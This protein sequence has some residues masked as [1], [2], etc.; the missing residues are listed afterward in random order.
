LLSTGQEYV[1]GENRTGYTIIAYPE[2]VR[3]TESGPRMQEFRDGHAGLM[4]GDLLRPMNCRGIFFNT[5][6]PMA[7]G[8]DPQ[9]RDIQ[10]YL[11]NSALLVLTTRPPID[12][13]E[14][15]SIVRRKAAPLSGPPEADGQKLKKIIKRSNNWLERRIFDRL[16]SIFAHCDRRKIEIRLEPKCEPLK[17]Q[18]EMGQEAKV[19]RKAWT[20]GFFIYIDALWNGG[21]DLLCAFGMSGAMTLIWCYLLSTRRDVRDELGVQMTPRFGVPKGASRLIVARILDP[22][23]PHEPRVLGFADGWKVG[24]WIVRD[25]D[26]T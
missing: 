14:Q 18:F 20:V 3:H 22:I 12:D 16:D 9:R 13:P 6:Y 10:G 23:I 26:S 25:F 8:L 5:Q 7:T 15:S 17:L 24:R 2:Q 19:V 4:L 11:H 1:G 21:P